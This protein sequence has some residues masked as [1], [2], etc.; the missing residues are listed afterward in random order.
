MTRAFGYSK[1]HKVKRLTVCQFEDWTLL[2]RSVEFKMP[3]SS[4]MILLVCSS[5]KSNGRNPIR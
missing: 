2:L 4:Y 3:R 1:F 5:P